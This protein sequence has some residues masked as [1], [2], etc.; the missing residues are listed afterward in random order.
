MTWHDW[1]IEQ[2]NELGVHSVTFVID[3]LSG[4]QL[5]LLLLLLLVLVL[6]CLLFGFGHAFGYTL[7]LVTF[8]VLSPSVAPGAPMSFLG[9]TCTNTRP[10]SIAWSTH[11]P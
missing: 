10:R 1:G 6:P 3:L 9:T 4:L 2:L 8:G 7:M 11:G 5:G